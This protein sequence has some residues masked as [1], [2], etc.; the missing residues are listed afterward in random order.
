[1]TTKI[2]L[3]ALTVSWLVFVFL[4]MPVLECRAEEIKFTL[5]PNGRHKTESHYNKNKKL[6]G[7]YKE[8]FEID[9]PPKK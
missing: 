3:R 5:Y 6:H 1:M 4:S 7:A 2:I 9:L 8:Y